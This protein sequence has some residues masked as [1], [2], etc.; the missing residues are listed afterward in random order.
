[1][2][3]YWS[4]FWE[5]AFRKN[6]QSTRL[7][8]DILLFLKARIVRYRILLWISFSILHRLMGSTVHYCVT[9]LKAPRTFRTLEFSLL[10]MS[11][12]GNRLLSFAMSAVLLPDRAYGKS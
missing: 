8:A 4:G 11:E 6:C 5:N 9:R 12:R 3:T 2:A 10:L 7:Y 1:M